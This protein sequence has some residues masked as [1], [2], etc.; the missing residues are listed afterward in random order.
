M[1]LCLH[2]VYSMIF[3]ISYYQMYHTCINIIQIWSKR[4]LLQSSKPGWFFKLNNYHLGLLLQELQKIKPK[5]SVPFSL[6]VDS[7]S[8]LPFSDGLGHQRFGDSS[9]STAIPTCLVKTPELVKIGETVSPRSAPSQSCQH[10][11]SAPPKKSSTLFALFARSTAFYL[12]IF[13]KCFRNLIFLSRT[14]TVNQKGG[15]NWASP[16][17]WVES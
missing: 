6:T 2:Y 3:Y 10:S 12:K 9:R 13:A 14:S 7:K 15:W 5:I 17:S 8:T 4:A 11:S 16:T 1:D